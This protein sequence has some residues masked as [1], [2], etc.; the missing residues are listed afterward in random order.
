MTEQHLRAALDK[1][2]YWNDTMT[3]KQIFDLL[4]TKE[5]E[6]VETTPEVKIVVNG[7]PFTVRSPEH[8][9]SYE[10]IALLAGKPDDKSLTI[11]YEIFPPWRAKRTGTL[12]PGRSIDAEDG[13]TFDVVRT[14][15]A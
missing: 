6:D 10:Q 4:N 7:L 5:A 12:R 8:M 11:T 2:G 1:A 9:V 14:D 15:G 13:M 3:I